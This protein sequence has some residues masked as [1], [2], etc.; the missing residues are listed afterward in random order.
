MKYFTGSFVFTFFGLVAS[1]FVGHYYGGTTAAGLGALFIAVILAILEISLS[2]DNAIVNAVVLKEMT[3]VWRHRFLTWGMLIAVFGMRLIFPLLIVTFIANVTPWDALI[4]AA[5]KPDEY[6]KL[7]LSAHL[8]V[9]AFGGSFLLMVALKY[10]YD[11]DKDL[12]WIPV[13]EKTPVYL[14]SKVEAI[15]VTLALIIL[16]IIS[17]FLPSHEALA[18]IM[19]GMAGLITYVIVDG[20]GSWLEASDGQMHDVHRASAGM[21]LY[22]EVLD[23][24]FSFDGVVGAFAIT[25][26]LFIIMIGLSIGAF[27]V[28]SLTIMFVEKEA[29][30]KF[31]FLEH[32][33]FYAIGILA[34]IMLLDPFLHIP[35]WVT[36]LSGGAVIIVSFLWSLRKGQRLSAG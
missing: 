5:T 17:H 20:I 26:N 2:F 30:T 28:R 24:S 34:M 18:F 29:L 31:A 7:M 13:L 33:A 27:F 36:G 10:F 11:E 16:A 6:A 3:P 35:E 32:G 9:A 12:H 4:M 14:G 1:Y 25:H 21:F 8:Q 15:E 19:A 23:A 22:L